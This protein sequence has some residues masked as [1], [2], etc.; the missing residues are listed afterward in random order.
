MTPLWRSVPM[1]ASKEFDPNSV[2]PGV[3]GFVITFLVAAVTVLLLID[4]TRRVRRTR[5]RG[6][7]REQLDA[8][9]ARAAESGPA[10]DS[11]AEDGR[12]R[13]DEED[14]DPVTQEG[15]QR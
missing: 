8:E 15:R 5:Y 13:R 11:L 9:Q 14:G 4:M 12:I 10:A 3:I 2:T 7:I 6:E 1:A